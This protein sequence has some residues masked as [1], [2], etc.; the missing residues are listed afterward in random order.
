MALYLQ[1]IQGWAPWQ[2]ALVLLPAGLSAFVPCYLLMFGIG[3]EPDLWGVLL[4][5]SVLWGAGFALSISALMVAGTTGV[6]DEEQGLAA[7]LLNSS[8]QVG[9]AR[10]LA[11]LTA[12]IGPG[13]AL[14]MLY[15]GVGVM[16]GFA[17]LTLLAQ[18]I[19][20]KG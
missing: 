9:G 20:G 7:G 2:M 1:N 4:P 13:T 8:L 19:R 5:A 6:A 18:V 15:P 16:L 14:A 3:P 17:V 10:G 11:V 12:A